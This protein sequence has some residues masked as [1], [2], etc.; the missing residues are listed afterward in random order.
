MERAGQEGWALV[1][2]LQST[3][4]IL[5]NYKKKSKFKTKAVDAAFLLTFCFNEEHKMDG[6]V[7]R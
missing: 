7:Y 4:I 5:E 2:F 3:G 6:C 1:V